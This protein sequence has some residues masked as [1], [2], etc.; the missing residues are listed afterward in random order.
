MKSLLRMEQYPDVVVLDGEIVHIT[1]K[2]AR[3]GEDQVALNRTRARARPG[4]SLKQRLQQ[5]Y[6]T[7]R[8]AVRQWVQ[9]NGPGSRHAGLDAGRQPLRTQLSNSIGRFVHTKLIPRLEKE[10][11]GQSREPRPQPETPRPSTPPAGPVALPGVD[12][13]DSGRWWAFHGDCWY[14]LV[15]FG[16]SR[17]PGRL[18]LTVG[19][20]EFAEWRRTRRGWMLDRQNRRLERSMVEA[21]GPSARGAEVVARTYDNGL[22]A[23]VQTAMGRLWVTLRV[24]PYAVEGENRR[25]YRFGAVEIGI[26]LTGDRASDVIH[27]SA[28]CVTH[29]YDHMFVLGGDSGSPICMPRS[30]QYYRRLHRLPLA[31]A[32]LRHLEAARV[33]LC[34]GLY[35]Q[36]WS[37]PYHPIAS[38]AQG[39][40]ST[41][42]ARRLQL[43]VYRYYRN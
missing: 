4:G 23:V 26:C 40:I 21:V 16:G 25:L 8:E 10:A 19:Q 43:P 33:T 34:S 20:Q 18:H 1:W 2:G 35:S 28:A 32:I 29:P 17:S 22:H 27:G 6:Q 11:G 14:Q 37:T 31:E 41:T 9:V 38:V 12:V 24:P 36:S 15:P 42:E 30:A 39:Q 5:A 13:L 7:H 3:R